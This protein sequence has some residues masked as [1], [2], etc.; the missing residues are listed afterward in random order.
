M[1]KQASDSMGMLKP[2]REHVEKYKL[3]AAFVKNGIPESYES[4]PK[5]LKALN[6]TDDLHFYLKMNSFYLSNENCNLVFGNCVVV[7][8]NDA[9]DAVQIYKIELRPVKK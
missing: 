2:F 4:N 6:I 3:N 9:G 7:M 1:N 8:K 5:L